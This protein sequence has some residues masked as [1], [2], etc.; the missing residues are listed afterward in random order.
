MLEVEVVV[1]AKPGEARWYEIASTA[2]LERYAGLV[3]WKVVGC[4]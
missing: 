1:E 2:E 4:W 3:S